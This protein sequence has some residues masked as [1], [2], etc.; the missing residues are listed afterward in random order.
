MVIPDIDLTV[1][2]LIWCIHA[3]E[4]KLWN[5]DQKIYRLVFDKFITTVEMTKKNL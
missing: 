5:M 2:K 3:R 4:K 1:D